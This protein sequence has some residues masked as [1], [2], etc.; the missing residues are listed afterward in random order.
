MSRPP[1][2]ITDAQAEILSRRMMTIE[3]D[4]P[5]DKNDHRPFVREFIHAV[6]DATG[7]VYSPK[8]L[9]N[10]IEAYAPGRHPS[11]NTLAAEKKAFEDTLDKETAAARQVAQAESGPELFDVLRTLL[12]EELGARGSVRAGTFELEK[13]VLAERDFLQAKLTESE[14]QLGDERVKSARLATELQTARD[15]C[16]NLQAQIAIANAKT[17]DQQA[18]IARFAEAID[19]NRKFAMTAVDQ[20]RGETRAWQDRCSYLETQ[21]KELKQQ[22]EYFRQMAYARGAPVPESLR[23]ENKK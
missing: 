14:Q 2:K 1:F 15:E 12:R 16:A 8:I 21:L 5:V 6:H 11:T 3:A 7:K 13:L 18:Q 22:M 9:R 10:L 19:S 20:V 23:Q 4:F 17:T